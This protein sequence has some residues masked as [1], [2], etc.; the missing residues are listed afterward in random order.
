MNSITVVFTVWDSNSQAYL[1]YAETVLKSDSRAVD[2]IA[3]L[4]VSPADGGWEFESKSFGVVGIQAIEHAH[5]P[6]ADE[7]TGHGR[8][9][10]D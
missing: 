5:K 3:S 10:C 1:T 6:S 9:S 2:A 7:V 8:Y 4:S